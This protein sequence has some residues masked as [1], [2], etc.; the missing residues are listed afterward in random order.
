MSLAAKW[1]FGSLTRI[2]IQ[3]GYA[4]KVR[5]IMTDAVAYCTPETTL[6]EVARKMLLHDCGAIPVL[7]DLDHNRPMG[8]ITDRDI[9]CR[10]LAEGRN[11]MEMTAGE[12]MTS[13]T[14]NVHPDDT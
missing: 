5:D 7:D 12:I 11:P 2:M 1:C 4:M 6:A 9:V 13:P 14:F 3:G 10:A 8:I